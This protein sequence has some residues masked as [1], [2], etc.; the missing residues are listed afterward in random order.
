MSKII[1]Q[2][3]MDSSRMR[4]ARSSSRSRGRLS[5]CLLGY[6]PLNLPLGVGLETPFP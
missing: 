5:Q 6:T 2:T 3:T 4:T 1:N